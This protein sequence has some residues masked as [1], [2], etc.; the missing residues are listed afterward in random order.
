MNRPKIITILLLIFIIR[1]P[2]DMRL[3]LSLRLPEETRFRWTSISFSEGDESRIFVVSQ[4]SAR[5][6]VPYK[7]A[8]GH[9]GPLIY[10]ILSLVIRLFGNNVI[11]LHIFTTV[12]L[13]IS[14]LFIY[15]ISKRL[16]NEGVSLFVSLAYGLFFTVRQFTGFL[17]NGEIFMMLPAIIAIF[18]F[19]IY[20]QNEKQPSATLLLC[21]LFTAASIL[22]KQTAFFTTVICPVTL[23][24]RKLCVR[25]Y[26]WSLFFREM[27]FYLSGITVLFLAVFLYFLLHNAIDDFWFGFYTFN[28]SYTKVLPI[29]TGLR[30]ILIFLL[31]ILKEEFIT[32]SA[33][34]SAVLIFFKKDYFLELR[35]F[36]YFVLGLTFFS[37]IGVAWGRY[38]HGHY[39][40]QMGLP[41]SLLIGLGISAIKIEEKDLSKMF[42]AVTL[43]LAIYS[44]LSSAFFM[45]SYYRK[46]DTYTSYK[47]AKYIQENT[48]ERDNIY[49][50]GDEPIIYFLANRKAP[51]RY[52]DWLY[53]SK[54]N[55]SIL[56][57]GDSV[58]PELKK[59]K[60]KYVVYQRSKWLYRIYHKRIK[61]VEKF[62]FQ[63]YH[64]EKDIEHHLI[65]RCNQGH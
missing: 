51:T 26:R 63:N 19:I 61:D 57:I 14:I 4:D 58:L 10:F 24:I 29:A 56:R 35:R 34:S 11:A 49:I 20:L 17:S 62:I 64:I 1:F 65:Y 28:F 43:T 55:G 52:F 18:C 7:T 42:Y 3:P 25:Q 33:L 45:V 46:T 59:N 53:I 48:T 21:G 16:F 36:V 30:R 41:F 9:K 31:S 23:I 54:N 47:I 60:P 12:Y 27:L 22:I 2:Q 6:G 44:V 40:L 38:M 37:F 5:G 15:L 8:W 32:F 39:F 13:L 50:L